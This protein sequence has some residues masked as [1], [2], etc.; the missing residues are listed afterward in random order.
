M[1][2]AAPLTEIGGHEPLMTRQGA[3]SYDTLS[4]DQRRAQNAFAPPDRPQRR[5]LDTALFTASSELF[6]IAFA[7]HP[8]Y[9]IA[10]GSPGGPT[11]KSAIV[12]GIST[13][14]TTS[15]VIH[16]ELAPRGEQLSVTL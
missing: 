2:L 10:A 14:E 7:P 3:F 9:S 16:N 6:A 1:E 12:H 4:A 8:Q 5:N 15:A 11:T 13:Y